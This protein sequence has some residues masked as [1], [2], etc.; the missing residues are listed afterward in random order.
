MTRRFAH[1]LRVRY[2]ECDMQGHVFNGHYLSYID[3]AHT[4]LLRASGFRYTAL[5]DE[6][7]DV[8]VAE[9]HVRYRGSARFE[10]ELEI[11]AVVEALTE[12]SMTERYTIRRDGELLTEATLRHVC[13]ARD[14]SGK[15]PWPQ[16]LRDALAP[17][18]AA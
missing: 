9:A 12:T 8:V 6:G 14:G 3:E 15:A 7:R 17:Y 16:A 10:D 5:L 4:E 18:V 1:R 11:E 2:V 13:V